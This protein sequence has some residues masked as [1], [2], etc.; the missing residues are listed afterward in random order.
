MKRHRLSEKQYVSNRF[1]LSYVFLVLV[2]R[3]RFRDQRELR[4]VRENHIVVHRQVPGLRLL[5]DRR[6]IAAKNCV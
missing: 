6:H 3:S 2:L 1:Y 4:Y 5:E